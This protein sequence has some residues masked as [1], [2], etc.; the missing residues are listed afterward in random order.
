M[1]ELSESATVSQP[2]VGDALFSRLQTHFSEAQIVE[3][4]GEIAFE[5]FRARF[6]RIFDIQP[7]Q[8]HS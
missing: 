7:A 2:V 3:L 4:A 8:K 6:N 1:L 5:N